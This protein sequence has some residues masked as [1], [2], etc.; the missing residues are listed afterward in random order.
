MIEQEELPYTSS[1]SWESWPETSDW[2]SG[3]S[4]QISERY[5]G[6]AGLEPIRSGYRNHE[7]H[8]NWQ[9]GNMH[10]QAAE[11]YTGFR[12]R[13]RR[14]RRLRTQLRNLT[15][16]DTFIATPANVSRVNRLRNEIQTLNQQVDAYENFIESGGTY[17][18][19]DIIN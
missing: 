3:L 14:I 7:D 19:D 18:D 11:D 6:L 4:D 15:N 17:S 2:S 5:M 13:L 8:I 16:F 9:L 10:G 12:M 1:S